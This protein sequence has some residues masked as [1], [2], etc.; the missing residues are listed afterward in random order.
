MSASPVVLA[1]WHGLFNLVTGGWSVAHRRSFEAF[2]GPK[3]DDWLVTTVAGLLMTCGA[4]QVRAA[5][6]GEGLSAARLLGY[7]TTATLLAVDLRYVP[8]G[9]LRP[10]YLVDALVEGAWLAAW[11]RSRP[12]AA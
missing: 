11:C 6:T 4:A 3:R 2:F 8:V 12:G 7:G 9:R 1:R 10:T 5:S